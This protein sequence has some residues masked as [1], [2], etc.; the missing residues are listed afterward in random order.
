[1]A[2]Q[3][4]G[5]TVVNDSRQLQNIASVDSTTAASITA[6]GVG[7]GGSLI[8]PATSISGAFT[9]TVDCFVLGSA[10]GAQSNGSANAGVSFT[11]GS[12]S[13]G[14]G[15]AS[16]TSTAPESPSHFFFGYLEAGDSISVGYRN[17]MVGGKVIPV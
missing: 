12:G 6:A 7:G 5:T 2:I 3:I 4:S 14:Y 8:G 13:N 15:H 10:K 1:M 16:T 11:F 9:A 17:V